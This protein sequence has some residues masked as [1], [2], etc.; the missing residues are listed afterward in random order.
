L[1]KRTRLARQVYAAL[2]HLYPADF[3]RDYADELILLFVDMHRAAV[4][5]GCVR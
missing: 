3:R 4:A 5:K 2:L 1:K